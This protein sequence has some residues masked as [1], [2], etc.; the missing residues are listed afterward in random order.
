MTDSRVDNS[1]YG[2]TFAQ[3]VRNCVVKDV[4]DAYQG[5]QTVLNCKIERI[6]ATAQAAKHHPD[7]YQTWG[8]MKNVIV[9]GLTGDDIDGAQVLFINQPLAVGPNMTDAAFVD[10]NIKTREPKGGPP[11]SQLQGP[12]Y[13]TLLRNV[14]IPNQRLLFRSDAQGLNHFEGKNIEFQQCKFFNSF[15]P[16]ELPPGVVFKGMGTGAKPGVQARSKGY[17]LSVPDDEPTAPPAK[18]P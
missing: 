18:K 17:P 8:D 10:W 6:R 13:N 1:A 14:H 4:F 16:R 2:F 3:L 5:S 11:F 15:K 9:Y 12:I 7:I